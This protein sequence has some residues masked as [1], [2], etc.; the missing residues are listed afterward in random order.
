MITPQTIQQITSRIDIIDVVGEFVKLKK[1]GTNYLG[2]CPFHNEKSPSFTVSPAKEIY[3][4]FGCGKSGNTITFLMEH[5]KYSYVEALRWLAARYHIEVEETEASPAQKIAQQVSDSLY[6]INSFAMDFFTKQYWETEAGET[7]AQSYMQHRGFLRPIIEKFKIGYNP[8]DRDSL[9]KALIK[10]QF[11]PELFARTGLVVER[12]GEWQDNYRDRIIFPIHNT[13]GKIIGFGARQIAKNDKSPK[14]INTPEN[15]IYSKSKILYGSYFARTSINSNDECLLVEGYT[16]VVSLH[17]AGI[18]NVVASGGTSL[19]MD[20][21]RLIKKYTHN[22][23][24]IYDGDAAGIKAALR[25][26][27]MA[28]EEGLN[29]QLVLIPDKEDPDS[30]VNKVGPEAFNAF[31]QANKKD[32]ILFQLDVQLKEVDGDMNKKN[33]LVNQIAETLSKINKAEDFTKL[34]DYVRKC[35]G[36]L[37]IDETGLTQLVN[38]FKRDKIVKEEKKMSYDEAAILMPSFS[39]EPIEESNNLD[40]LVDKDLLHEKNLVRTI[41]ELGTELT[42][43]GKLVANFLLEEMEAFPLEHPEMIH[44]MGAYKKWLFEGK[45]PNSKTLQYHEDPRVQKWVVELFAPEHEVS[46]RWNDKL[47]IV[48]KDEPRD[49]MH[50]VEVSLMY[51]KLRKVKKMIELNQRDLENAP[52]KEQMQLLQIHKHLKDVEKELTKHIGTVIYK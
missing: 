17:Q 16:D 37:R 18:E 4:C 51:F 9:A 7:I 8:S 19:T 52:E 1:R 14:Y 34:Q 35:A 49:Y 5:E 15:E 43:K 40:L 24:I 10:N 20:Q 47:G 50:E 26:L 23:T 42:P 25:G 44:V 3:K 6:A 13:T 46:L 38:K 29:V 12:N 30:Y 2:N 33:S 36:L 45:M 39:P 27:D 11:N 31:V 21:L 48:K 32:F 22:L 28:L 41:I